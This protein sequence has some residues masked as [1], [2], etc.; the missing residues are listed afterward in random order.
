MLPGSLILYDILIHQRPASATPVVTPQTP[1]TPTTL[2]E[3]FDQLAIDRGHI[4][5]LKKHEIDVK[6]LE[7]MNEAD[8]LGL[9]IPVGPVKKIINVLN[10]YPRKVLRRKQSY[11]RAEFLVQG[12][13]GW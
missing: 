1:I 12:N 3:L 8:L 10:R 2:E 4:E 13:E 11:T 9:G 5:L 7:L 6:A